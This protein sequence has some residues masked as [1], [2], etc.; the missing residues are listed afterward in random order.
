M[1]RKKRELEVQID[2]LTS[3]GVNGRDSSGKR[4]TARGAA[5]GD[6]ALIRTGRKGKGSLLQVIEPSTTRTAH[7][8]EHFLTCGGC[9]LQH[10]PLQL[11]RQAKQ[12]MI[13]RL[14][15]SFTGEIHPIRGADDGYHYR[16]KLELSFGT[17]KYYANPPAEKPADGSFLGMHPWG[18]YSKIVPLNRCHLAEPSI[19]QAVQLLSSYEFSSAWNTYQHTG[20]WRYIVLREG[21][22]LSVNL[23]TSSSVSKTEVQKL[24]EHLQTLPN[25]RGVIWTIS[26]SVAEVAVGDCKEILYGR[27][28][29]EIP[30]YD[31]SMLI[32]YT[33]FAQV[34]HVGA[35]ILFDAIVEATEGRRGTLLDLYCG[36]GAIGLALSKHF[37]YIIG[38]ELQEKAIE[39]AKVN[40]QQHS[41]KGQ[42]VAGPVE[43]ILPSLE[44]SS[45]ATIIVDPPREGL[46]PKAA[47]FLAS[48]QEDVLIYIACNPKSLARDKE[49]LEQQNWQMDALWMVDLF[50]QTP[51]TECIGR[52]IQK[53]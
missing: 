8:C 47:E 12:E 36:S 41:I 20:G 35:Q 6:R 10:T 2:Q 21:N 17:R 13:Q 45:P 39:C 30:I 50:P 11:Q 53:T 14:F 43:K 16:N 5:L 7:L 32:P 19:D 34:N 3:K 26:D 44:W 23:I 27:N 22:G 37:D 18:W 33:G 25:L 49:I 29:L 28:D 42:W 31:K 51:H 9:Q 4:W 46:H 40:A 24:T 15:P 48:Q 38:V 1:G 52:F